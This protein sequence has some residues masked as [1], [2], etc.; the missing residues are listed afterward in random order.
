MVKRIA[1]KVSREIK[2]ALVQRGLKRLLNIKSVD[3]IQEIILFGSASS[4]NFR[5]DSDIDFCV[6]VDDTCDLR[7][8]KQEIVTMPRESGDLVPYDVLVFTRQSYLKKVAVGG[9][10]QII[11]EEGETL[12]QRKN[13]G[14]QKTE[15]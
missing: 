11:D 3:E 2:D 8:L 6:I 10:C 9:V 5:E 4:E 14:S 13:N 7:S 15:V 1:K 12:F